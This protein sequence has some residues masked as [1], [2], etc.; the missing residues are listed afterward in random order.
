[1]KNMTEPPLE[2]NKVETPNLD[3]LFKLLLTGYCGYCEIFSKYL[4]PTIPRQR[5]ACLKYPMVVMV[6]LGLD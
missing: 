3:I 2:Q 1:M 6:K 4:N 5:A